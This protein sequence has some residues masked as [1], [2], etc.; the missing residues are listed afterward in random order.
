MI[1]KNLTFQRYRA[2]CIYVQSLQCRMNTR[3]KDIS[4]KHQDEQAHMLNDKI[5]SILW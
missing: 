5:L 4:N 1:S 3:K 2:L